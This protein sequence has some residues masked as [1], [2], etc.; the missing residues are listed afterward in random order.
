M[1]IGEVDDLDHKLWEVESDELEPMMSPQQPRPS[2]GG[3][4]NAVDWSEDSITQQ[5]FP[6]ETQ[7][8]DNDADAFSDSRD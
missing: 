3:I 1:L 5:E 7:W 6:R 4:F 2:W 8:P